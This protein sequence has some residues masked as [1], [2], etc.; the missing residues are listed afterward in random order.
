MSKQRRV[1][2][3]KAQANKNRKHRMIQFGS[4]AFIV[5]FTSFIIFSTFSQSSGP[6]QPVNRLEL[7]PILGNPDAPITVMEY[8]AYGCSAC[9][10]W[11]EAGIMEQ[12]LQEFP[13]Q[14][15]FIY[16]DMPVIL[17]TWSQEMAEVAQCALDQ[18]NSSFW[19]MHDALFSQTIQGRSSQAEAVG[20]GASL[21]LGVSA[22]Q[23]CI[24]ANTHYETVRYDMNRTEA[25]VI[26]GTPTWFVN[27]QVIFNASPAILRQAILDE[28]QS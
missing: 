17:P 14:V 9:K 10:A 23:T 4:L 20:L 24:D 22:L 18:S 8:A 7:D 16:R 12:I 13:D 6:E 11:H 21:G 5:A 15:R 27:G 26:R 19:L 2:R 1:A 3:K 25:Q 28:L